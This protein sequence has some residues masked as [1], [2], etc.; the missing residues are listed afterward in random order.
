MYAI[1]RVG[2]FLFVMPTSGSRIPQL[3]DGAAGNAWERLLSEQRTLDAYRLEALS[4]NSD[5][6]SGQ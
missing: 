6:T 2:L 1:A 5:R 3:V 4:V